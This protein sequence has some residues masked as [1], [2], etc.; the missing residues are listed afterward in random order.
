MYGKLLN[1]INLDKLLNP[2]V[3]KTL[4]AETLKQISQDKP[5]KGFMEPILLSIGRKDYLQICAEFLHTLSGD[6][7]IGTVIPPQCIPN[8]QQFFGKVERNENCSQELGQMHKYNPQISDL[9][10]IASGAVKVDVVIAFLL[11]LIEKIEAVYYK[12]PNR[13]HLG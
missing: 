1:C 9:F 5:L 13:Q 12:D 2:N 10:W 7:F 4:T 8:L 3:E 11:Y 6:E